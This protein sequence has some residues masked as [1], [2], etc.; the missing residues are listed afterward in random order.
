MRKLIV[1]LFAVLFSFASFAVAQ[2]DYPGSRMDDTA[3]DVNT[4]PVYDPMLAADYS[5]LD[6]D[7][8]GN[9][10]ICLGDNATSGI[11]FDC[12][13]FWDDCK[14]KYSVNLGDV[15]EGSLG[16]FGW[17]VA[18]D[19]YFNT[20]NGECTNSNIGG[21]PYS[22]SGLYAYV[23]SAG[24]LISNETRFT[25]FL[26][27]VDLFVAEYY[28]NDCS[29]QP[30][31]RYFSDQQD[32]EWAP[33]TSGTCNT[34]YVAQAKWGIGDCQTYE[35]YQEAQASCHMPDVWIPSPG[36]A[37]ARSYSYAIQ[38]QFLDKYGSYASPWAYDTGCFN[39]AWY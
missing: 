37:T 14:G 6:N 19:A 28:S 29:G 20:S 7:L 10:T 5:P 1:I 21:L 8:D 26:S 11:Y 15:V 35:G 25:N 16:D 33:S 31:Y 38:A 36:F 3:V 17:L 39:V 22:G 12:Q 4:L 13:M 30:T 18:P 34:G 2:V 23:G 24:G 27:Y 32:C 9:T